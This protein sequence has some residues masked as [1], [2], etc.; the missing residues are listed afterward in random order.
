MSRTTTRVLSV[1]SHVVSG[2]V[3]NRAAA[4]P[5]Q[6]LD[7]DT[8]VINSLQY[9]NHT[10]LIHFT[11]ILLLEWKYSFHEDLNTK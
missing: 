11:F 10:G 3:G 9:S 1:Q 5:L 4:F 8:D 6:L 7:I 2:Y